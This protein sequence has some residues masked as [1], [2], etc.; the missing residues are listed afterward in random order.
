ML[1]EGGDM[2]IPCFKSN[3]T[4]ITEKT[5]S[6]ITTAGLKP[7]LKPHYIHS[8][9][10]YDNELEEVSDDE[11]D[12]QGWIKSKTVFPPVF[13]EGHPTLWRL[14]N[15]LFERSSLK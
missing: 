3:F 8:I 9:K 11:K 12:S 10:F 13:G 5:Y 1:P 14:Y 4:A 2:W 7:N 15:K 6:Y